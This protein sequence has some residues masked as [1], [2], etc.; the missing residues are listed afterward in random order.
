[1]LATLLLSPTI[2]AHAAPNVKHV[3]RGVLLQDCLKDALKDRQKPLVKQISNCVG[4]FK[5]DDK[6]GYNADK[7]KREEGNNQDDWASYVINGDE[8]NSIAP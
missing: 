3:Q 4:Q 7:V 5:R 2:S 6:G 8:E 1:M